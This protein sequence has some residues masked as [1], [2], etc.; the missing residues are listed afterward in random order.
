MKRLFNV[1]A[2]L[3][4]IMLTGCEE[5][6]YIVDW[7]PVNVYI[8]AVDAN[9]NSIISPEMP[10]MT[11]TFMGKTYSVKSK[12]DAWAEFYGETKAYM[13]RMFGLVAT[14]KEED[15]KPTDKYWLCFGEIDGAADMDEDLVLNW[16]DG[17]RDVIHYHCSDHKE[18]RHPSC[19][20][21][22]LLNGKAH[23]GVFEF[24]GKSL[25]K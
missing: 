12:E 8:E 3:S 13:P 4:A 11:L 21:S 15:G 22:W 16:P 6:G 14:L 24:T 18:G 2:V 19:K 23:E 7:Y 1:F 25:A 17:S 20:R 10:G 9:G 5:D